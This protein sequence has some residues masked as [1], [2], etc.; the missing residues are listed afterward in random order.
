MMPVLLVTILT[1]LLKSV[2]KMLPDA[3]TATPL[4]ELSC[5]DVA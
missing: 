1:M 5:A 2:M 3:S 4:G